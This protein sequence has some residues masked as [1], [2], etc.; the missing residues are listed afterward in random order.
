[1]TVI[2]QAAATASQD[3]LNP[4]TDMTVTERPVFIVGS[5]RSGTTLLQ[6][7]IDH[8]TSIAIPPESHLFRKYGA[9]FPYYGDLREP[10]HLRRLVRD[11]LSDVRITRWRLA[12]DAETFCRTLLAPNVPHILAHLFGQYAQSTGKRRWGDKTPSHA[13]HL[14]AITRCFPNAQ[15][16]HVVRDGRDVAASMRRVFLNKPSVVDNARRWSRHV[17]ACDAF[18][19]H[20]PPGAFLKVRY[21]ELVTHPQELMQRVLAFLGE[22]PADIKPTVP[23]TWLTRLYLASGAWTHALAQPISER[24]VGRYR[25][26][27]SRRELALFEGIAGETLQRHGYPLECNV[28]AHP[29]LYERLWFACQDH[30]VSRFLRQ[31]ADPNARRELP[32]KMREQT[33]YWF[34]R[35]RWRMQCACRKI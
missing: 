18:E 34:R 15:I 9:L 13:L 11:L 10:K 5:V 8:Y 31:L 6:V 25:E 29:K 20:A 2:P 3:A 7:L 12:V 33:Q 14:Y 21:E 27:L 26:A 17:S 23:Q 30:V 35:T 1:M 19:P 22:A 4:D 24:S 28:P 16:I 32:H